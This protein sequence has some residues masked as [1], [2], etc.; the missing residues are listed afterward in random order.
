MEQENNKYKVNASFYSV[1]TRNAKEKAEYYLAN[2]K[3]VKGDKVVVETSLGIELGIIVSDE[4]IEEINSGEESFKQITR[5]ATEE[6]LKAFDDVVRSENEAY[7][8]VKKIV[9]DSGLDMRIVE[10]KYTL[11]KSKILI[12]YVA[13][14]RVDFRDL[15]KSLANELKCRIELRQIGSRD[16]SAFIGGI[17]ICG[18]PICCNSFLREFDGISINM[19]KN[20]ML[21][22]NIQK[23]SGHCGKLLCCL[24]YEDQFYT[25]AKKGLD[26]PGFKVNYKGVV[27]K[28]ASI[29]YISGAV[30]LDSEDGSQMI[31]IDE[32]RSLK[33]NG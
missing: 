14:D 9:A 22:L 4:K 29:N 19:A 31:T 15:L 3:F 23:L 1:N 30:R 28:V 5:K 18:L 27:Y 33:K 7:P 12:T 20:Q 8:L 6:D 16:R 17:G 26:K 10:V 2:E 11:D 21:A 32:L 25:E 24:K 13:D